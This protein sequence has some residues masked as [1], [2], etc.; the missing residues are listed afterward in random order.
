[1]ITT[2]FLGHMALRPELLPK[3]EQNQQH[4]DPEMYFPIIFHKPPL[5]I[6][7]ITIIKQ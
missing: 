3:A 4:E 1:M 7:L 2:F 6:I 5:I